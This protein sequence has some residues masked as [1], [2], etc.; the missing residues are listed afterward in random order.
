MFKGD[1]T[2]S[3]DIA[4]FMRMTPQELCPPL[5]DT[6][7]CKG[8]DDVYVYDDEEDCTDC[9]VYVIGDIIEGN[10]NYV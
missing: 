7:L 3:L 6:H 4:T 9:W 5:S 1:C 8:C 2:M 10:Y